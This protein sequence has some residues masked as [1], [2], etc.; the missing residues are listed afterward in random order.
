MDLCDTCEKETIDHKYTL[1]DYRVND[2]LVLALMCEDCIAKLNS[3]NLQSDESFEI[4]KKLIEHHAKMCG[5]D[6]TGV[7]I[8]KQKLKS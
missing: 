6:M 8:L 1:M 2:D 5:I 7:K 3:G 4:K